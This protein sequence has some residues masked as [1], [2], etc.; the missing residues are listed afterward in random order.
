MRVV[1]THDFMETYG[2][3]ERVTAELARAFPDAPVVAIMGRRAVARRMGVEDRFTS[4]VPE[5]EEVLHHYRS[6][7]PAFPFLVD[8]MRVPA[9]DVVLS[10]SYAFA[11][12]LRSRT[13]ARRICYC[14][15][16]LR[17][18]WSM[19]DSYQREWAPGHVRGAM[20]KLFASAMRT[21]DWRSAQEIDSYLTTSPYTAEL[22]ERYYGR[23]AEVVAAPLNVRL[24]RPS[25]EP[26]GDYFLLCGRLVE[27]YK[28]MEIVLRAF[29]NLPYR[30][31]VAGDGPAYPRLSKMASSNVEFLGH[32]Q[33]RELVP[34][35]QRCRAAIFPSR[36]DFGLIPLEVMA[37]GRPV[38]AYADG[39]ALHTV[40]PGVTGELFEEQSEAAVERAVRDFR[41]GAY[42]SEA[43][44]R[45]VQPYDC[46][47]FRRR[48]RDI[49]NRTVNEEV[50][51]DQCFAGVGSRG[52]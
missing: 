34:A 49:V 10:S 30:L 45:T 23:R 2:G 6:L 36:D 8:H 33:D 9:A 27:P 15:G 22:I 4:L 17:F 19:T 52:G 48:I 24:F 47:R 40:R 51:S 18:A 37:C 3:A 43:I 28:R 31:L 21:G 12:R 1:I 7:A 25:H 26:P 5:R 39:G 46:D 11:H 42:D 32:L 16:P 13:S 35:M 20:F 41:S 50:G 29:R 14:H 44:R 38:L